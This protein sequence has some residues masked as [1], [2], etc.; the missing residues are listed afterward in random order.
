MNKP[1]LNCKTGLTEAWS[2]T[3]RQIRKAAPVLERL[4]LFAKLLIQPITN[5]C[6]TVIPADM[7]NRIVHKPGHTLVRCEQVL[8]Q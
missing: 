5:A 1:L 8:L 3:E 2:K 6:D 4:F 7:L